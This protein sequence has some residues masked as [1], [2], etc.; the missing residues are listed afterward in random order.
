MIVRRLVHG[1]GYRY[2]LHAADL[3][4]RPD[5]VLPR[6]GKV[7][8]VQGCFWHMHRCA[9]CRVPGSHTS[10][11]L[12]K[13]Q[14]NA[15]RDKRNFAA[16]RRAGWSVLVVWECQTRRERLAALR[17]RLLAFLERP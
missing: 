5:I 15:A 14:G 17:A 1:M 11:W 13:L 12:R 4:G 7:I 10:Y 8:A 9:R 6:L 2:R 16:L 3:P